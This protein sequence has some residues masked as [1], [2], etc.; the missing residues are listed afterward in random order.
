M[1]LVT[2]DGFWV[3]C[4]DGKEFIGRRSDLNVIDDLCGMTQEEIEE[5]I[6]KVI[7]IGMPNLL[8]DFEV[9]H[10]DS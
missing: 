8:Y 9:Q 4:E 2:K 5:I 6:D 7:E 10:E 1:S 3:E